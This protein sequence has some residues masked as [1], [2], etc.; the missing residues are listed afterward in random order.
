VLLSFVYKRATEELVEY[1]EF[2]KQLIWRL[3]FH[4]LFRS[5]F[6]H[7]LLYPESGLSLGSTHC[8]GYRC[9][10]DSRPEVSALF[11]K[12]FHLIV[13]VPFPVDAEWHVC[14]HGVGIGMTESQG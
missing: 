14:Q 5:K 12:W 3:L 11:A 10:H 13:I 9:R 8:V 1:L 4:Y 6:W 7:E 2:V